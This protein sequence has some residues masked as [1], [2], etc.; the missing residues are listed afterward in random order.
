MMKKGLLT[1]TASICLI[2]VLVT[3]SFMA[4]CAKPAPAPKLIELDWVSF[5]PK[6]A[7]DVDVVVRG[8]INRVNEGATGE[9]VL[10]YRGGPETIAASDQ[11]RA[12]QEGVVDMAVLYVGAFEAVVP[13]I[14]GCML[15]QITLDE[16]RQPGGS[17]DYINELYKKSGLF[18]LGR[19]CRSEE[20]FRLNLNKRLEKPED[21]VGTKI[22]T[23]TVARAC[24][25]AW[26]ATAV[27]LTIPEY[28][29]A[30]ER[31]LVDGVSSCPYG[32]WVNL[33]AQEVTKYSIDCGYYD[34]TVAVFMNLDSWNQLPEHLQNL[35]I[36][37]I[38]LSEKDATVW[39]A[40]NNAK[41]KQVMVEA[42]VEFYKL[43]PDVEKW[44]L[45]TAYS[46]AWEYQMERFPEVTPKLRELLSKK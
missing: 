5:I 29:T 35:M 36:E 23:A 34:N 1:L 21:F 42:G 12:V 30:M 17:Y 14:G 39:S 16:E 8:F 6:E 43:S 37:S 10:T 11:G 3:V 33:G 27:S 24:T 32:Q 26:G 44:F 40:E 41:A 9:L 45:E 46:S 7:P 22:G 20:F 25:E 15:A 38:I 19:E 31:G 13:G 2:L 4:A 28:Y 18:Y